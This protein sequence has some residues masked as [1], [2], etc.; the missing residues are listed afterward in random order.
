MLLL[1]KASC[2]VCVCKPERKVLQRTEHYVLEDM[3]KLSKHKKR[4]QSRTKLSV[5][6]TA[7]MPWKELTIFVGT[8]TAHE[9]SQTNILCV[10]YSS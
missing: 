5:A 4:K 3:I 8:Y 2:H 7:Y 6:K 1:L 10:V 9:A